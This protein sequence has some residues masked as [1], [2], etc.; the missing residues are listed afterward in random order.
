MKIGYILLLSMLITACNSSPKKEI[1]KPI[2]YT[3]TEIG[4]SI[5]I[6]EGYHLTTAE[7]LEA[8]NKKGKEAIENVYEGEVNM[9][10]LK[11]LAN[12]ERNQINKF[13]STIEPFVETKPGEYEEN[14]QLIKKL[15]FDTYAKQKIKVDS[16]SGKE[17]IKGYEF[18]AFYIKIYGP[19]NDYLMT[20]VMLSRLMKGYDFGI[21]INYN[22]EADKKLMFDALKNSTFK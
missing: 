12:F 9:D 11:S 19:S 17:N 4:W 20:Q 21:N 10:N 15:V 3:S 13:G 18:N 6:P 14:N 5:T 22:T 1:A 16:T 7:K 2:V 8:T